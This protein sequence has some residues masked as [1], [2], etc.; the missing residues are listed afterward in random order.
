MP[1][2]RPGR[3][4][5][6]AS[7]RATSRSSCGSRT[8]AA[9]ASSTSA[10]NAR[11]SPATAPVWAA[12]AAAPARDSP[13]FST[14]TPTPRSAHRASAS[15]SLAPSPSSS[16]KSAI[17]R[18]P[19]RAATAASQ[20]AA[21]ST[22][23]FPAE[24]SVWKS[25]PRR[26]PIALTARFPLCVIMATGPGRSS[27]TESPQSGARAA[28]AIT[29]LPFG[30]QSGIPACPATSASS[31]SSDPPPGASP[32]PAEKTI[33]PAAAALRRL[34]ERPRHLGGGN[35]EDDRVHRLRQLR[36][37]WHA[38]PAVHARPRRVNS[39]DRTG[40]PGPLEIREDRVAVGAGP[41][42]R[43]DDRHRA[44]LQQRGRIG[45]VGGT[46]GH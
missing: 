20:S 46:I 36:R 33:G 14:T 34:G 4:R 15:A 41:V 27:G 19:S 8:Q 10:R 35:R 7:T 45:P 37:R 25:M 5:G 1:P 23:W 9:P 38:V 6:S 3:A 30:P 16:R 24:T 28:T 21:S 42:G 29:P 40:E 13:T 12:A 11:W 22:V 17:E 39:P 44:R 2:L 43:T 26:E 18:T 31:R 32:K